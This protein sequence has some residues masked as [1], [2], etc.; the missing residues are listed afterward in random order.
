MALMTLLKGLIFPTVFIG[1]IYALDAL[2]SAGVPMGL[3]T[4]GV[5]VANLTVV[6]LLE[7]IF[8][9]RREWSWWHDRQ[10]VNDLIHGALL[11]LVGPRLG[12]IVL[13]STIVSGTAAVASISQG[14]LWPNDLP[15]WA[16]LL[17]AVAIT[18][19][20]DWTKHWGYHNISLMWPIHALHHNSEKM[21]TMKAGRLHFLEATF[22]FAI[23]YA[24][25][26]ILGAG[27]LV[28]IW[29]AAITNFLGNL[30]HSNVDMPMPGFV[31]YVFATPQNHRLHH[32]LDP[33][34]GRSNMSSI[35]MLPDLLF[36]TFRHPDKHPLGEVG[37][38]D[39][40]IP[41]NFIAQIAA[42]FVW[43]ALVRRRRRT[44]MAEKH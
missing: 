43:P 16:Q 18:D 6:A 29:F 20:A 19:F 34:L 8:P 12:Q 14:G 37:I 22:R 39:N 25:L 32:A 30:N 44:A 41:G 3:A 27:P 4:F 1:S 36:G 23:L 17:L 24:P 11:V 5:T 15:L 42:P 7:V 33:D 31:H 28:I 9:L 35:L 26:L 40:P 2:L 13:A 21:H 38:A 10:S